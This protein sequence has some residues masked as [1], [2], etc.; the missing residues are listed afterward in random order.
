MTFVS[1]APTTLDVKFISISDES[2]LQPES[3]VA[4]SYNPQV[5]NLTSYSLSDYRIILTL[6]YEGKQGTQVIFDESQAQIS[7]LFM[8]QRDASSA[9]SFDGSNYS[10]ST[11][12][13]LAS[14]VTLKGT[15]DDLIAVNTSYESS[16][17]TISR[18]F[19]LRVYTLCRSE[20]PEQYKWTSY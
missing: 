18:R 6:G 12:K 1:Y 15:A 17:Y 2:I 19:I 7:L 10:N 9:Q 3:N 8:P 11:C 5:S 16:E 13:T 20:Q 4:P 14:D